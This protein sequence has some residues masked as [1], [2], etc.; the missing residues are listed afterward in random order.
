MVQTPDI[1]QGLM[2][3]NKWVNT[4]SIP[5]KAGSVAMTSSAQEGSRGGR[6]SSSEHL[7]S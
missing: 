7:V 5:A 3:K 6:A 4:K 1:S 2:M